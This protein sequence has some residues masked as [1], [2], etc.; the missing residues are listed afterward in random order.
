MRAHD[1]R[2]GG[3]GRIA[4]RT[5]IENLQLGKLIRVSDRVSFLYL[6][7]VELDREG[8]GLRATNAG[9][10]AFIPAASVGAYLL[11]PG[12]TITHQAMSLLA[13]HGSSVVWVGENGVR[14]YAHGRGLTRGSKILI[15]QARTVSNERLRLASAKR[16]YSLRF[17]GED[18]DGLGMRELLGRE[19]HRMKHVYRENAEKHGVTWNGRR[20]DPADFAGSDSINQALTAANSAL[21]GVVHATVVAVGASPELG[22]V[23]NGTDRSFIYDISDVM[24]ADTSIPAAFEAVASQ[25]FELSR[26][27]RYLIRDRVFDGKVIEK[28][29]ETIKIAVGIGLEED[30]SHEAQNE[31]WA[32]E[33]EFVPGGKQQL[34]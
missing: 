18:L 6:E 17:P 10:E 32:G 1:T 30:H 13:D 16:L 9:K 2:T 4:G 28:T 21:Y 25:P 22:I 8:N 27:V 20:Y 19:G 24:K 23:H 12:T 11:G 15:A 3:F 26:A 29:I 31:L 5:V 14:Y 34:P 33:A 7:M